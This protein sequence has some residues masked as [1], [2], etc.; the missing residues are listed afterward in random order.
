MHVL[1]KWL[2]LNLTIRPM[3]TI[4]WEICPLKKVP[5]NDCDVLGAI[6]GIGDVFGAIAWILWSAR[7]GWKEEVGAK[8]QSKVVNKGYIS[9]VFHW[10][11][12][13]VVGSSSN[14]IRNRKS[15][16]TGKKGITGRYRCKAINA[17]WHRRYGGNVIKIR[18][19]VQRSTSK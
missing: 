14:S 17:C 3:H 5:Q 11:Q 15:G 2:A 6:A 10:R 4:L 13:W 18:W 7:W 1:L 12:W 19:K 16:I 8:D 9:N